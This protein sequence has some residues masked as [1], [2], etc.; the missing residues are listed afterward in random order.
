[1][2]KKGVDK[3]KGEDLNIEIRAS[4]RFL[5]FS[6]QY[7]IAKGYQSIETI[8]KDKIVSIGTHRCE[9]VDDFETQLKTSQQL[10]E[11]Y[12]M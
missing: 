8:G 12:S 1:M 11:F 3:L 10:R 9:T 5:F 2:E 4:G 6:S 7:P